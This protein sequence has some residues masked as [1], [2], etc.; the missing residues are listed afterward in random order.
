MQEGKGRGSER[1]AGSELIS[2]TLRRGVH[3]KLFFI[4]HGQTDWNMEGRIQGSHDSELNQTG[5]IQAE[6]LGS[7][8]LE[9]N[10]KVSKIYTSQQKRAVRTAEILSKAI[11]VEYIPAEGLQEMNLG[12]WEGLL[13]PEVQEKFPEKYNE[14]IN[15]RRYTK[16]PGGESYQDVLERVMKTVQKIINENNSDVAIVT[17]GAVIMCLRCYITNTP[18][19]EMRRFRTEN[20]A[21]IEFDSESFNIIGE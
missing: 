2:I 15:N 17:H 8:L 13:W 1:I 6:K 11:D 18:F 12:K 5:I 3:M 10:H 14:W 4:R 21:I 19:N 7:K 16:T 9:S 20:A